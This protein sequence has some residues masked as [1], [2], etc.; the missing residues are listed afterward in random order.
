MNSSIDMTDVPV[1]SARELSVAIKLLA[2]NGYTLDTAHTMSDDALRNVFAS[3]WS[4][5]ARDAA[6]KTATLVRLQNLI[7][8]TK[9]RSVRSM[10]EQHGRTGVNEAV[11]VAAVS[12]LNTAYGFNPL[13][14]ARAVQAA[15]TSQ[16][17]VALAA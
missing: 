16:P 7:S 3:Y 4:L 2:L 10:L 12:R 1:V 11:S 5:V 17:N 15:L 13:K 6:R 8:V 14:I 9:A